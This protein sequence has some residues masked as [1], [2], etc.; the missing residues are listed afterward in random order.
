[1]FVVLCYPPFWGRNEK[2]LIQMSYKQQQNKLGF[3]SSSGKMG[4]QEERE[5]ESLLGGVVAR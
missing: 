2:C 1:M 5:I 4:G 3:Q